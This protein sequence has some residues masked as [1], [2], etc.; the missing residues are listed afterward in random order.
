MKCFVVGN[1]IIDFA[2]RLTG[3]S[4]VYG[5]NLRQVQSEYPGA[6]L[7]DYE[8]WKDATAKEQDMPG[9]WEP[10]TEER[11]WEML[12]VLPPA[13]QRKGAFLVGEALDHHAK[14]GHGRF[15]A[16]KQEGENFFAFS[17]PMTRAEF[18]A[19]FGTQLQTEVTGGKEAA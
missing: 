4:E 19:I 6:T 13:A 9:H 17:R 16:F 8:E 14:S 2:H 1:K 12:E 18:C 15:D 5:H 7:M 3:L 10:C 11:Y